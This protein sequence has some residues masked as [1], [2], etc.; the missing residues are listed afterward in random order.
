MIRFRP[1][2][3]TSLTTIFGLLPMALGL[4]GKSAVWAPLANTIVWGLAV[5]TFLTLLIIPSVYELIVDDIGSWFRKKFKM[6][7]GWAETE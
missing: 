1:I 4:G 5:S 2:V 6:K 3:M 7:N